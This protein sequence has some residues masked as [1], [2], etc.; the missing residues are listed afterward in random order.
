M[1]ETCCKTV[2]WF[3]MTTLGPTL[4]R[5]SVNCWTDTAGRCYPIRPKA[6]AWVPQI[7]PVPKIENQRACC[8]FLYAGGPICLRYP[9]RQTAQLFYRPEGYHGPSKTLGCSHST[10]GGLHWRT[11]TL[12]CTSGVLFWSYCVLCISFE[13]AFVLLSKQFSLQLHA[14]RLLR[15][16]VST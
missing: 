16:T 14:L 9:T 6:P 10:E 7:R 3:C 15:Y 12:S 1:Y 4:V 5:L 2:S 11:I 8:A 13:M